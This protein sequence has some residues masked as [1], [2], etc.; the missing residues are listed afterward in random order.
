MVFVK[1]CEHC[2][3]TFEV[4]KESV[5]KKRRYCSLECSHKSPGRSNRISKT[6]SQQYKDG[7]LKV[8]H[9]TGHKLSAEHREALMKGVEKSKEVRHEKWLDSSVVVK[10]DKIDITNR[11]LIDY[12]KE[13]PTCEICGEPCSTGRRLAV[14]HD[15]DKKTFRGLLCAKCNTKLDWYISNQ[16]SVK[17]YI[18]KAGRCGSRMRAS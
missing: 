3:K 14:D 13:H 10:G 15:H 1:E 11:E 17:E 16:K 12:R 7:L 6:M 4:H 8:P 9:G 2:G 18:D 5:W